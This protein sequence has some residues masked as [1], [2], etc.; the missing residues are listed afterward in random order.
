[1]SADVAPPPCRDLEVEWL[2]TVPYGEALCLQRE[3][4]EA[5]RRGACPDRL[6]LLEHPPVITLGRRADAGNLLV[7]RAEL[8]RRGVEVHSVPRGGDVTYHAPGQLVG[9]PIVD[10]A[11]RGCRDVH[12]FLRLLESVLVDAAEALGV[13]ADRRPGMTGVFVAGSAP[14]RKLASI[15]I[16]LRG[17]LSWHGFALNVSLDLAGF[18]AIVPCGL[19]GVEMTSIARE[20]GAAPAELGARARRAVVAAFVRRIPDLAGPRSGLYTARACPAG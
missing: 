17:W 5:R 6:L 11:A 16:G 12:R 20:L 13:A 10:L 2:G 3:V 7:P 18:G 14:P 4:L 8:A 19:S 9:Y 15:G 1:M